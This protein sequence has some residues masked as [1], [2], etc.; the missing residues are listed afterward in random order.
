MALQPHLLKLCAAAVFL[1]GVAGLPYSLDQSLP[2]PTPVWLLVDIILGTLLLFLARALVTRWQRRPLPEPQRSDAQWL[3]ILCGS[4]LLVRVAWV[5]AAGTVP[6]SDFAEYRDL[7]QGLCRQHQYGIGQPSAF[8]PVGWPFVLSVIDCAGLDLPI[9]GGIFNAVAQTATVPALFF[10]T[11]NLAGRRAAIGASALF[12]L[13][14]SQWLSCSLLAT[15]PLFTLLLTWTLYLASLLPDARRPWRL[16][17]AIGVLLGGAAYVRSTALPL[18]IMLAGMAF[19]GR[20]RAWRV[21]GQFALVFAIALLC[22]LP[23]GLRNRQEMGKFSLTTSNEGA[24]LIAGN[25]EHADGRYIDAPLRPFVP[26]ARGEMAQDA[27]ARHV[28]YAWIAAHPWQFAQLIPRKWLALWA[29]EFSHVDFG[30]TAP[31]W[32]PV[33]ELAMGVSELYFLLVLALAALVAWRLPRQRVTDPAVAALLL[34][35][36]VHVLFHGQDRYHAPLAPLLCMLAGAG[37]SLRR[38]GENAVQDLRAA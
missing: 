8:R 30:M 18:P 37:L 35:F 16:A 29:P 1:A 33:H 34:W 19:L 13:W 17:V 20:P 9:W 10:W 2:L 4:A 32:R 28:A 38:S 7:A 12:I 3:L 11:R 14:P 23:W 36:A 31:R 15:E 22:L 6:E 24:T 25:A 27:A 5:L 21:L 26:A